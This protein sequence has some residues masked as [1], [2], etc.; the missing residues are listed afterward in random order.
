MS[1]T[2]KKNLLRARPRL[3][4]AGAICSSADRGGD[5]P[6]E[7][8]EILLAGKG[9][10]KIE[11]AG[12]SYPFA[13]GDLFV[14]NGGIAHRESLTDGAEKE[15]LFFGVGNLHLAGQAPN[16]LLQGRD[17][18]LIHTQ[19]YFPALYAYATQLIAETEGTQPLHEGIAESLLK[20]LLLSVARLA[21]F[22]GEETF[23]ENLSYLAAKRY[24]D[25]HF[26]EIES[27]EAVCKSLYVNKYYLSHLFAQNMGMPPVRYLI[28]KRIEL[29]CRL[30]ET[31]DDNVADIGKQCGYPDPCYFSRI[32][33]QIKKVT[34]LRYR[35]LFKLGG[36]NEL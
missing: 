13:A 1:G 10:G 8:A 5:R 17:Y 15:M 29:A 6:A 3:L 32:F 11:I 34:P 28:Q 20:V 30:L 31:S 24:F 19:D 2:Y 21:V 9:S 4:Y 22:D 18:C 27:I 35:Y 23:G 7:N 16:V 26:T 12:E 36:I 25:E 14:C 33:K